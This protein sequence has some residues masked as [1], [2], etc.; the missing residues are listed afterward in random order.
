MLASLSL[1]DQ[2][3]AIQTEEQAYRA[4]KL[5]LREA[6]EAYQA[7]PGFSQRAELLKVLDIVIEDV[8]TE[9]EHAKAKQT[10]HE[11]ELA[12]ATK[13]ESASSNNFKQLGHRLVQGLKYFFNSDH[14][15]LARRYADISKSCIAEIS[16]LTT[17]RTSIA[18]EDVSEEIG[19]ASNNLKLQS[20][21]DS[22][23]SV[24]EPSNSS[25]VGA[26]V[27]SVIGGGSFVGILSALYNNRNS[28]RQKCCRSKATD[29][30]S[31]LQSYS[32]NSSHPSGSGA[33]SHTNAD[34]IV[35]NVVHIHPGEYNI[36]IRH[37]SAASYSSPISYS[38][39]PLQI[40]APSSS[41]TVEDVTLEERE[42]ESKGDQKSSDKPAQ[43]LWTTITS[44]L[45]S[46][47][48]YCR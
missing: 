41:V 39:S 47:P 37:E 14:A 27:G 4:I 11:H 20:G 8:Q 19:T 1:E 28:I 46:A 5:Q 3:P 31:S 21:G 33:H 35:N 2:R 32:P 6:V 29:S 16:Q 44:A 12:Q 25:N 30:N 42:K 34:K 15:Y 18:A 24:E 38:R 26:I 17:Y 48:S 40:A 45:S 43:S 10:H 23:G 22:T 13:T 36:T 7:Q 9:Y